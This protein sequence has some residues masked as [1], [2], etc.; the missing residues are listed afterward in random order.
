M[1]LAN[2]RTLNGLK[3]LIIIIELIV[4]YFKCLHVS[5]IVLSHIKYARLNQL[6]FLNDIFLVSKV[7]FTIPFSHKTISIIVRW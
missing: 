1:E 7:K 2:E 3:Y 4:L 5:K 6:F